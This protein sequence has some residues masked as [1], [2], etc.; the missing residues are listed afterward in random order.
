MK[1]LLNLPVLCLLLFSFACDHNQDEDGSINLGAA[2]GTALEG[3]WDLT[4]VSGGLAGINDDLE[5]GLITWDFDS[6]SM[7][8]QITDNETSESL[9]DGYPS[10]SYSYAVLEQD[11][12]AY[13]FID[14]QEF[15]HI[16]LSSGKLVLDGNKRSK[17][18]GADY[19]I[20]TML[21]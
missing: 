17:G 12:E 6:A 16:S 7:E 5:V 11:E 15:S 4:N 9:Y 3:R 13:L 8:L 1:L 21:R 14:G 20:L 18:S 2:T 10:G 19:F